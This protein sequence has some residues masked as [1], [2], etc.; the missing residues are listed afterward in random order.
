MSYTRFS[1]EI[2]LKKNQSVKEGQEEN[3]AVV[4]SFLQLKRKLNR[5]AW[6]SKNAIKSFIEFRVVDWGFFFIFSCTQFDHRIF[7]NQFCFLGFFA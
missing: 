5:S 1:L 2:V 4:V 3:R 7:T 6:T